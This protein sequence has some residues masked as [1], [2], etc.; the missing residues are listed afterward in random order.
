VIRAC[1]NP[2]K[3]AMLSVAKHRWTGLQSPT[4]LT[5][6]Q[7]SEPEVLS[8]DDAKAQLA[9]IKAQF[10]LDGSNGTHAGGKVN[11]SSA[12]LSP[13]SGAKIKKSSR[14]ESTRSRAPKRK[15]HVMEKE[16]SPTTSAAAEGSQHNTQSARERNSIKRQEKILERQASG[17]A[18]R[19]SIS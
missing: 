9:T 4:S 17:C 12:A 19:S 18:S 14:S 1:C 2:V 16:G 11:G 5:I 3:L 7:A 10:A 8:I 6:L 13:P 15:H